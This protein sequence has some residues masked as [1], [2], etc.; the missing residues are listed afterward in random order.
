MDDSCS[1][2]SGSTMAWGRQVRSINSGP[3]LTRRIACGVLD[4]LTKYAKLT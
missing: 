3:A 2:C 4:S 1:A